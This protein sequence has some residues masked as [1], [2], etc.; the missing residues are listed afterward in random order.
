M[1]FSDILRIQE[2]PTDRPTQ[3]DQTDKKWH[4]PSYCKGFTDEKTR[5]KTQKLCRAKKTHQ[6]GIEP[7]TFRRRV[8]SLN[9]YTK[10]TV[11][12]LGR[13][14]LDRWVAILATRTRTRGVYSYS[15]LTLASSAVTHR[16]TH[17]R[18]DTDDPKLDKSRVRKITKSPLKSAI[19]GS[20]RWVGISVS[21]RDI[22]SI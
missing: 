9:R 17:T 13:R 10:H 8:P 14:Y 5:G 3:P 21:R 16:H 20:Q 2:P 18:T 7:G 6:P 4:A 22:F 11:G 19:S 12:L 15:D 1:L